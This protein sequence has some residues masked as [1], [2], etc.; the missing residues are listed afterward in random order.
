MKLGITMPTR[1]VAL[2]KVAEY[3]RMA[4]DAGFDSIWDWEVYRNPL[5]MLAISAGSTRSATL[6]TGLAAVA[7]RSPFEM[8]N[9]AAD[10]DE[11]SGGRLVLGIG[12]GVKEF[13]EAFHSSDG[14]KPLT[15]MSEYIDVLR[16]SWRYLHSGTAPSYEGEFYR[17][18]PP[19]ANVWGTRS[20]A[21]PE[22]PVYL[23][24][25]GPRM[26]RLVGEKADGWLGYSRR[27]PKFARRSCP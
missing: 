7:G 19:R 26:T 22:I 9:A 13:V 1:T 15:R 2:P 20:M 8:A 21:R 12:T 4:D 27:R 23:A 17:F 10:V 16:L 11:L 5:T 18:D 6:G 25:I 24:A 3:A 14:R